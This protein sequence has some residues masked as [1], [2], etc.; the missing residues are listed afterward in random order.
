MEN[1]P[2]KEDL[3]QIRGITG[4]EYITDKRFRIYF[5]GEREITEK[6]IAASVAGNW[7]LQEINIDRGE[8][9]DIFKQISQQS[10]K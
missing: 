5:E 8:L 4:M 10:T 2:A 7:R 9:D 6:I 3:L 1:P